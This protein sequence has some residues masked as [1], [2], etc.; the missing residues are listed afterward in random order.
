M[1]QIFVFTAGDKDARKHLKD[2]ITNPVPFSV[3]TTQLPQ[4]V[5]QYFQSLMPNQTG[6]YAWGA[7]PGERNLP[8]WKNM[9]VGDLVLTVFDNQ[10]HY[11]SSVMGKVHS[12]ALAKEIWGVDAEGQTWEYMYFLSKPQPISA[13]VTAEPLKS[14]LNN[15]YRGFT[16]I[17][18]ER[19]ENIISRYGSLETFIAQEL[20]A[21]IPPTSIQLEI[22]NLE[23]EVDSEDVFDPN[24]EVDGRKKLLRSVVIRQGQ[25]KFRQRLL[26]AYQ[27]T[28]VVTGCNI[29]AVLQAAHIKSYD[30]DN[31]NAIKNGL[32]MRAD[33]HTL[34]DLGQLKIDESGVIHLHE[35]LHGTEYQQYLGKKIRAPKD[36]N[37]AP[38]KEA[39]SLKFSMIL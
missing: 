35:S 2:S 10:Y 16:R 13:L 32:L 19:T 8:T 25:P 22:K 37:H 9:Q 21:S 20:K 3:L 38:S 12:H 6:F 36:P 7:V 14:L 4:G 1:R 31:S 24:N 27:S 28:C 33:I 39:L 26:A 17:S 23:N 30:G 15:G 34:F 29:E 5:A 11:F 18:H